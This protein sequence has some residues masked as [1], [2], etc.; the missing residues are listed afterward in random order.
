MTT[1]FTKC[2]TI[3][4]TTKELYDFHMDTNNIKYI[5]PLDTKVEIVD[6]SIPLKKGSI[7]KIKATKFFI[8][9]NLFNMSLNHINL[10]R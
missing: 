3:K 9:S 7:I 1:I 8:L 2:S 4:C 10:N 5:T 6:I